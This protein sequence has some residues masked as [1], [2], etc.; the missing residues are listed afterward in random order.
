MEIHAHSHTPGKKWNHYFWEFLMLFLAVFSGFLAENQR[1]HYVEQKRAREYAKSLLN[2]LRRD[3]SEIRLGIHWA[4]FTMSSIDSLVSIAA[5]DRV[6]K[7]APGNFYYHSAFLCRSFIIDWSRSTLD[8][9][10]QSGSLRYFR[11]KKLVDMINQYYLSQNYINETNHLDL[12]KRDKVIEVRNHI[13]QSRYYT[14]F[15]KMNLWEEEYGHR[16]SPLL[17]SLITQRLPLQMDAEKEID[18]FINHII[19]RKTFLGIVAKSYY[20]FSND[21]A[22]EIIQTLTKEYH[23]K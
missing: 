16:P 6:T 8:Q 11:N 23:L 4:E 12:D 13:L 21:L 18:E 15:G 2:D 1:E 10:I 20:P 7:D 3:T 9:L 17:D 19:D 22:I 5:K 14:I